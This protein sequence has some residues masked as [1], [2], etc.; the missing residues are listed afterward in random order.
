[1]A[2]TT[3]SMYE[4]IVGLKKVIVK[5][6]TGQGDCLIGYFNPTNAEEF[7]GIDSENLE[8]LVVAEMKDE[9]V[10]YELPKQNVKKTYL[11]RQ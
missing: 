4:K 6:N 7:F 11:T 5:V 1:M 3:V 10:V 9:L 8:A 2:T